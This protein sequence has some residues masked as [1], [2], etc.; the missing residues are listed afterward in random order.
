MSVRRISCI[1]R[2]IVGQWD[3][4]K[5]ITLVIASSRDDTLDCHKRI[6]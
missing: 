1:T 6:C 4:E 5:T 3:L 2:V